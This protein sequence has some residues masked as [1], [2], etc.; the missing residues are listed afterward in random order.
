MNN[1]ENIKLGLI[2][3]LHSIV[4]EYEPEDNPNVDKLFLTIM[5]YLVEEYD[6]TKEEIKEMIDNIQVEVFK[7]PK[8]LN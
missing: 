5:D 7:K 2:S 6:M 8:I 1:L 3:V 4:K